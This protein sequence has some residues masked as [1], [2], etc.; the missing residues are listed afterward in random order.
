VLP[1]PSR[2]A[3]LISS[4]EKWGAGQR[5]KRRG[6]R[7][8]NIGSTTERSSAPNSNM[9]YVLA[10]ISLLAVAHGT[11]VAED[12]YGCTP[13]RKSYIAQYDDLPFL[14]PDP[15]PIPTPYNGLNYTLFQV[16]QYDGFIP[17]TSGNQ[18]TMA[19]GGS[20]NIS[21]PDSY[22]PFSLSI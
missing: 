15:S 21:I 18:W 11:P 7:L 3:L 22:A 4:I 14:E 13:G 16:D 12:R 2:L 19:Y 9:N 1:I 10:A 8:I 20:G 6:R 17:P 5:H